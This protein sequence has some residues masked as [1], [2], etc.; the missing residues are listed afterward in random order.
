MRASRCHPGGP[1]R[2]ELRAND[3]EGSG[4]SL[5]YI[6]PIV[7]HVLR[8]DRRKA[9]I[10]YPMNALANS[11][12]Q[13]PRKFLMHGYPDGRGPVTFRKYTGQE[14]DDEQR[15]IVATPPDILLTN[16]VTDPRRTAGTLEISR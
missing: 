2:S 10:V 4:K 16:Y 5:P 1:C 7:D 13:E 15:E 11:Q 6:I 3:R 8:G 12:E 9:I 14:S